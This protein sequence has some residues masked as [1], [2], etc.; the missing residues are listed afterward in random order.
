MSPSDKF[1]PRTKKQRVMPASIRQ[2][3]TLEGCPGFLPQQN[4]VFSPQLSTRAGSLEVLCS[5]KSLIGNST[6]LFICIAKQVS[7]EHQQSCPFFEKKVR[8]VI[9]TSLFL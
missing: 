3:Q 6:S 4:T 7:F 9:Y 5:L 1:P 8:D 2:E